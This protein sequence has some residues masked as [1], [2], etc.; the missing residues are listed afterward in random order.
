MNLRVKRMAVNVN[1]CQKR[2]RATL[3]PPNIC[4]VGE[5]A[6]Q[7]PSV[8]GMKQ[9]HRT[10]LFGL[11][12]RRCLGTQDLTPG[13]YVGNARRLARSFSGGRVLSTP[14]FSIQPRRAVVTP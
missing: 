2:W 9:T 10:M 14:D 3:G 6:S 7:A 8:S 1:N 5:T 13:P 11:I 4:P 12:L